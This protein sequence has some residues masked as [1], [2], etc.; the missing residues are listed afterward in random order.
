[1][2]ENT[3]TKT[4]TGATTT[5]LPVSAIVAADRNV[6][7]KERKSDETFTGLVESVRKNG[8]IC[9]IVV[10]PAE[11]GKYA[12]VD[13]HR[14]FAAAKAAGMDEV[15]VDVRDVDGTGALAVTIAANVQ[16]LENEPMLEAEAMGELLGAGMSMREVAATIGKGEGYVAR[17]ARLRALTDAWRSFAAR[18]RCTADLLEHVAAHEPQLQDRVAADVDL[19]AYEPED[20]AAVGWDEFCE[21]FRTAT[22]R[23]AEAGFDTAECSGCPNNTACH[24]FL[25]PELGEEEAMCQDA[26]CYTR[27]H[28]EAVEAV[29]A[30]LRRRGTPAI[31][32]SSKWTMPTY[33]DASEKPNSKHTQAYWWS[34]RG[35]KRLMWS[36]P[37]PEEQ[38]PQATPEERAARREEKRRN[39]LVRSARDK[40]RELLVA[41]EDTGRIALFAT[42]AGGAAFDRIAERRLER[43]LNK[44]WI[45]DELCDDLMREFGCGVE[46]AGTLDADELEAYRAV[47]GEP[48][49]EAGL[50]PG[51]RDR[52]GAEN[53][54]A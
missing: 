6:H 51:A 13:G 32:V 26:A 30:R 19:G 50:T 35:I 46:G 52:D 38:K 31:E 5:T 37:R 21:A 14:R 34:E 23:L 44:G 33:W 47:L 1:M 48:D 29:I 2:K 54:L 18:H 9:R 43:D 22:M 3:K 8:I 41:D 27:K 28:N 25:F 45:P 49:G 11:D 36:I 12:I 16:R 4:E 7:A 17:R 24:A 10:R 53:S 15:P 39:R 20:D 40:L 42:E